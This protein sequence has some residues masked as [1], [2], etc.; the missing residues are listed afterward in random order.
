MHGYLYIASPYSSGAGKDPII[1]KARFLLAEEFAA[2]LIKR[3]IPVYSPIVHS[4]AIAE[5]YEM[6]TEHGNFW[7]PHNEAMIRRST[8]MVVLM[9]DGWK[10]ST[11]VSWEIDKGM[12]INLPIAFARAREAFAPTQEMLRTLYEPA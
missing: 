2:D 10:E 4:H 7:V 11:G 6:P 3:G 8:G 12:E 5:K 9:L 1:R